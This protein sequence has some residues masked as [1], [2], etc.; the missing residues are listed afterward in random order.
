[1]EKKDMSGFLLRLRS[2]NSVWLAIIRTGKE[3]PAGKTGTPGRGVYGL[4]MK[5][6]IAFNVGA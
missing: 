5:I 6:S 2:G 1:M 4:A 3:K